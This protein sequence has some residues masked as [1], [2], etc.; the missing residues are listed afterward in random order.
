M[1]FGPVETYFIPEVWEMIR[2][3]HEL[4]I[5]PRSPFA[6]VTNSDA[7]GLD[8]YSIRRPLISIDIVLT[9]IW[10]FL[11]RPRRCLEALLCVLKSRNINMVLRNLAVYPKSLWVAHLAHRRNVEHIHAQWAWTPGTMGMVASIVSG[12]PWSCTCHRGDIVDD[13]LLALKV[14]TA[15]FF[16]V[17]SKDG[18]ELARKV[19][20]GRLDGNV[21]LLHVGVQVPENLEPRLDLHDPPIILCPALL[22]ERKGQ[23]YL[24]QALERMR[25]AGISANL[26]LAGE[27]ERRSVYQALVAERRLGDCVSFLGN[28]EHGELLRMLD[29]HRVDIVVLPSL[30]EGIPVCLLEA[31]SRGIPVVATDV[32]GVPELLCNGAGIMVPSKDPAAL[33][34]AIERVLGD[35]DL[36]L[37]MIK[38][39]RERVL[40]EWSAKRIVGQLSSLLARE[41][42]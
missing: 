3:G 6:A 13:N 9:A 36:R 22:E 17:I 31:M 16:R 10:V 1:P 2:Q 11:R 21:V 42:G 39:A 5:V 32:G 28:V 18:I 24:F 12:I 40:M 30:H 8:K 25:S 29:E 26:W 23:V 37:R 33:A 7:K 38:E 34:E 41:N 27:G 4:C 19:C 35:R 20:G 14:K 15:Q